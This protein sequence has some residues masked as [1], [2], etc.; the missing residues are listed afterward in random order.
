M[1]HRAYPRRAQQGGDGEVGRVVDGDHAGVEVFAFQQG[2]YE[3][4]GGAGGEEEDNTVAL[5]PGQVEGFFRFSVVETRIGPDVRE[6]GG[7]A[8]AVRGGCH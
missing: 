3:A 2:D 7:V 5:V 4:D 6:V 8:A 1:S